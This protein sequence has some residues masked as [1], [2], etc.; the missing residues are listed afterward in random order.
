ME[1]KIIILAGFSA[2]GKDTVARAIEKRGANFI[3]SHTTRPIRD[4]ETEGNPY[5]FI[6]ADEFIDMAYKGEF[7]E[8]RKYETILNGKEETWHY[9][10]HKDAVENHKPYVVVLDMLG[11]REF[12]KY[13]GDRCIVFFL[14]ADVET[15]RQRI[16][17]RG[18][19]DEGEFNRRQADDEKQFPYSYVSR[20]ADYIVSTVTGVL[21]EIV[22][23]ILNKVDNRI[24]RDLE[25]SDAERK[26]FQSIGFE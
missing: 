19:Y 13:F 6:T 16:K 12:K 25:I 22:D 14:D 18:D 7:I 11:V 5:H 21:T 4:Y 20:E 10:V 15:R 17:D 9:G 2:S 1:N 26:D 24:K 8:H 23:Y 3:I